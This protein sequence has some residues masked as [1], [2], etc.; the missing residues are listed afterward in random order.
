MSCCDDHV[1]PAKASMEQLL[2]L[3]F[4]HLSWSKYQAKFNPD[5]IDRLFLVYAIDR[6][7]LSLGEALVVKDAM[8]N[9]SIKLAR[10]WYYSLSRE[11]ICHLWDI[12]VKDCW[13][14]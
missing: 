8:L 4:N 13:M 3:F 1:C 10:E 11:T 5:S 14:D 6:N 9:P 12:M 7:D 2:K